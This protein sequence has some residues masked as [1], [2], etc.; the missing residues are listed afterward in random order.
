MKLAQRVRH[1]APEPVET[2]L[3]PQ[4]EPE[5]D[6]APVAHV[7]DGQPVHAD[8]HDLSVVRLGRAVFREELQLPDVAFLVERLDRTLPLLALRVVQLAEVERLAL[9]DATTDAHVLHHAP[10]V[11]DRAVLKSLCSP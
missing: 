4:L 9:E 6:L 2:E 10:V 3:V 7:P 5:L 11:V 1:L 8:A